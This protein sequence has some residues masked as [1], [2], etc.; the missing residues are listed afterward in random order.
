MIKVIPNHIDFLKRYET[1]LQ[2][3]QQSLRDGGFLDD[4]QY[5]FGLNP[6][7]VRDF[8]ANPINFSKVRIA[9]IEESDGSIV[10]FAWW[11]KD[12]NAKIGKKILSQ[13]IWVSFEPKN[14]IRLLLDGIRYARANSFDA[15]VIGN[16]YKNEKLT[17]I[18]LKNDFKIE[19]E[20][21]YK[22]INS[23]T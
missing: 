8:W 15:V 9:Y 3:N 6:Q 17:R 16:S 18:L 10:S 23:P 5:G 7:S 1:F 20:S 11:V 21:F 19:P 12:F 4:Y 2:C 14:S 13:Y 22:Q